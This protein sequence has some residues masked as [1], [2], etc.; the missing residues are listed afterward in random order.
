MKNECKVITGIV[1]FSYL[2]ALYPHTTGDD[3]QTPRYS[4]SLV[5]PKDDEKTMNAIYAAINAAY[6]DGESKL[7]GKMKTV[8]P[9]ESL[10]TPVRDGDTE[11]PDDPVYNGCYFVNASNVLKP[12]IVDKYCK[13]ITDE[14]EIYSGMYGRASIVFYAFNK[15]GNRGIACSLNNLQKVR[16]GERLSG[17]ASAESDFSAFAESPESREPDFDSETGEI[18]SDGNTPF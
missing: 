9:L 15:S 10:K 2:F 8:P 18:L 7:K 12:G 17:I 5:I 13:P 6:V 1:R 14:N 3:N 4:V 11:R 16:D